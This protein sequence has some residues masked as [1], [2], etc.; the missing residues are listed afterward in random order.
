MKYCIDIDGTIC[1]NTDG[2]Y[3]L[4]E[5]LPLAIDRVNSL[6]NDGHYIFFYT[7][8]GTT[9]GIDWSEMTQL[10]LQKWGVK[11]HK[12][13]F[14]KPDADIFIDDKAIS[15]IDFISGQTVL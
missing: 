13:I 8:R 10:Q 12:I 11:Y 1:T 7:A 2:K 15:A 9:T 3:D 4:A 14:G 6:Y 5:P